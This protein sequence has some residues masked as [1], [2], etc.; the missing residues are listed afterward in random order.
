MRRLILLYFL[1]SYFSLSGI[2]GDPKTDTTYWKTKYESS[3]GFSQTTLTNW[4]K[5]GEKASFSSNFLLNIYKEYA[6][7]NITWNSYLG[8]AYGISRNQSVQGLRKTND[9]IDLLTKFGLTASKRWNYTGFFEFKS[10]FSPGYAYPNDSVPI[11]KFMAPGYFQLSLGM[12]YRPVEY[13]A[14]FISPGGSRLTVVSDT[15]L[16]MRPGGAF[17]I[18]GD[19]NTLW[20]VGGSINAIFKKDVFKNVNLFSKLDIFSNYLN[21]QEKAVFSWENNILMKVNKYLAVNLSTMMIYDQKAI[22]KN[23]GSTF[24]DIFQFKETFGV[25]LAYTI[26]R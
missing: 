7:K 18:Y 16:T 25:G 26:F 8:I 20:Q 15:A 10:Q 4:A 22:D 6:R 17:G 2:A 14:V 5:G 21:R 24:K 13:F 19:N 1:I 12:N 23:E 3:L 11:S 9:M